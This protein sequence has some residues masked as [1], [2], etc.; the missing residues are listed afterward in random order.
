MNK[1]SIFL[2]L[3][4]VLI[5]PSMVYSAAVTRTTAEQVAMNLYSERNENAPNEFSIVESFIEKEN[6][7]NIYFIFRVCDGFSG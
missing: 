7:E 1:K 5:I 4:L 2:I 3:A 6:T